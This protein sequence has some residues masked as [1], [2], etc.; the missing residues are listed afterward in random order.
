MSLQRSAALLASGVH[1][2]RSLALLCLAASACGAP[3][4]TT[5]DD[6]VTAP[7]AANPVTAPDTKSK[8]EDTGR[9][10]EDI[11]RDDLRKP[12]AVMDFFDI[13]EGGR[14]VE[15]MAGRGYY[16]DLLAR[17]VGPQGKVWAHN[18]PFVLK[19]FAEKPISERLNNPALANVQRLDTEL[20]DPKLPSDLDAVIVVLFYHDLFWQ[21]VDRKAMNAAVF[22]SLRPGGVFG[23]ID[24]AA[25]EGHGSQD[26]KTLHRVEESL[27]V[28]E[29][30]A[31]GFEL[32]K[33]SPLLRNTAD[34]R[35]FNVFTPPDGR[36]KTD[37][38]VLYFRRPAA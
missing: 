12:Q 6:V 21:E 8:G 14:V 18:S 23:V 19:R 7:A 31:A 35:D 29:I 2:A 37:R 17:R 3:S 26:V 25:A 38:F 30:T 24:H 11:A 32:V 5:G 15:L 34:T 27:V 16:A 22:A 13:A 4:A 10:A 1:V 33:S 28:E 20:E 9:P 36:D